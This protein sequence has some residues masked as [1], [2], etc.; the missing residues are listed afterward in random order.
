MD[1]EIRDRLSSSE[2]K[3]P[4]EF[5][6]QEVAQPMMR[7]RAGGADLTGGD[8]CVVRAEY[9]FLFVEQDRGGLGTG[10]MLWLLARLPLATRSA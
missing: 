5:L 2:K 7:R 9:N 8:P 6:N 10:M 1:L 3:M 4:M